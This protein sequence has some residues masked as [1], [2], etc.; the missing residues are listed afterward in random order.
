MKRLMAII[1]FGTLIVAYLAGH[2][3][4]PVSSVTA[5]QTPAAA[6]QPPA[7]GQPPAPAGALPPG[8]YSKIQ[9]APEQ[10][11]PTL[12]S[13]EA[14]RRAHTQ[15]QARAKSGQAGTVAPRDF[16]TPLVTRNHSYILL[17]RT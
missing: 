3:F 4:D 5:N 16:M 17:H 7:T 9:L 14:L 12:E 2:A 10:G 13:G 15:L 6:Q 8:Q 1:W 11:E